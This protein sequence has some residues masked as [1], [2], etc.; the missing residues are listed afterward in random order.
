MSYQ[1]TQ[2]DSCLNTVSMPLNLGE[3]LE[4]AIRRVKSYSA[5]DERQ[6]PLI[7]IETTVVSRPSQSPI[8]LR[9]MSSV[10][11][12][13]DREEAYGHEDHTANEVRESEDSEA[14]ELC[15]NGRCRALCLVIERANQHPTHVV[16]H[17]ISVD[18]RLL[19]LVLFSSLVVGASGLAIGA[20]SPVGMG[21]GRSSAVH[22]DLEDSSYGSSSLFAIHHT[23]SPTSFYRAPS[24]VD[25]ALPPRRKTLDDV[26][27]ATVGRLEPFLRDASSQ[28]PLKSVA[29][30]LSHQATVNPDASASDLKL[31]VVPAP[32]R[33]FSEAELLS[34][35]GDPRGRPTVLVF[36]SK[37][38]RTCRL[39]QPKMQRSAFKHGAR[40][41]FVYHDA[42]T[43]D[44]FASR[45]ITQTPTVQVF[46]AHGSLADHNVYGSADLPRLESVLGGLDVFGI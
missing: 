5:I 40:F 19:Y 2:D 37:A 20:T 25:V 22:M 13:L 27:F 16:K 14:K 10:S 26:N 21:V 32:R 7:A 29:H 30:S 15:S 23:S 35:L 1:N 17:E 12:R 4:P 33:V 24:A 6:W 42:V 9:R 3:E 46:D 41:L 11:F 45:D 36:G 31:G 8:I 34:A 44:I 43:K 39:L 38:C 18:V 28:V